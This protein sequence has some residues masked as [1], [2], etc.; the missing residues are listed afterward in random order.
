[1][2][3]KKLGQILIE[4][5]LITLKQLEEALD[6]QSRTKEFLGKILLD[7]NQIKELDLLKTLSEQFNIPIVN[8]RHSYTDWALIKSFGSS[9]ILDYKCF[10]LKKDK[11]SVTFAITNPLDAW[12]LKKIEEEAR[13]LEVKLA[14]VSQ[15][16]MLEVIKGYRQYLN[17]NIAKL[18]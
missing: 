13:G 9:S 15:G 16:D 7:K 10:P 12:A 3:N 8:L 5:G 17:E 6:E 14:L 11:W 4:K 2:L 18:F 1:M